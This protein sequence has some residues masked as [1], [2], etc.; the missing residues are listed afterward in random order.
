[1]AVGHQWFGAD[2]YDRAVLINEHGEDTIQGLSTLAPLHNPVNLLG[3]KIARTIFSDI[4]HV[5][6]FDTAFHQSMP[7][8]ASAY[9][10]D[11]TIA[12]RYKAKRFGFHGTSHYYV[13][14][15]AS[16]YLE[17]DI[18][19]LRIISCHLG[20]GASVCAIE[21]GRSV[22]TSMGMTPLEGLVMGTRS[23]DID[24]GMIIHLAKEMEMNFEE[25]D[26]WLN[27]KSGLLGLSGDSNDMRDIIERSTQGDDRCR[28]AL[29]VFTH[30]LRKYIGAY[31]AVMGGV[32]AI[33]F[34]GG[35]GEKSPVIRH[36]VCQRLDYQEHELTRM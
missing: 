24:P 32:D 25:L 13:A 33:I 7:K 8:R 6:V 19:E 22:E 2:Q 27:K 30:R 18:D 16:A 1:M 5:A 21:Y 23:G 4:P 34:T 11:Q 28:L 36:R 31:T 17:Q 12:D 10:I 9:A 14:R 35:I 26:Q 3:I 15:Q 20:N 29:Q